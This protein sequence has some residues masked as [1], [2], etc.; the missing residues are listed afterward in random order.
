M[1]EA[2]LG[3]L[4]EGVFEA[5]SAG[6]E[7]AGIH[8]MTSRVM[9]EIGYDL[10]GHRSKSLSEFLGR[11]HFGYLVTVCRRAQQSCPSVFPGMGRRL[12][13]DL[14]DPASVEGTEEERLEAFR[15][16]RDEIETMVRDFIATV[17]AGGY[18]S[19]S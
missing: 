15:R 16:S 7:P 18:S 8:P 2:F 3:R 9:R 19:Q 1:A 5:H 10:E 6:L 4:G 14:E 11:V 13:W 12:H 17:R